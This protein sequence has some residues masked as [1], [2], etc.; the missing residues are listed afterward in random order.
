MYFRSSLRAQTA[1]TLICTKSGVSADYRKSAKKCGKPHF[2][3]KKCALFMQ[4]GRFS[5]LFGTGPKP[6]FLCRLMF[7]PFGLSGSTGNTQLQINHAC[8]NFRPRCIFS[9]EGSFE[10][11]R[12]NYGHLGGFFLGGHCTG[13]IVGQPRKKENHDSGTEKGV[14]TKGVFSLE[15]SRVSKISALSTISRKWSDSPFRAEKTMTATDVTGFDAI[16]S[17]GFFATFSRF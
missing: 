1:K 13:H 12:C 2:L 9:T 7:L 14:I 5:A 6:H 16:F 4:K 17:I 8:E 10:H 15:E 3:R 11:G